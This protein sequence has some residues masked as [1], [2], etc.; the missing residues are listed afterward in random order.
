MAKRSMK[1]LLF[2]LLLLGN[3]TWM[4]AMSGTE[5]LTQPQV[6]V[7]VLYEFS[8]FERISPILN[9][10]KNATQ[11]AAQ[12]TLLLSVDQLLV[13]ISWP[14]ILRSGRVMTNFAC[15]V[16]FEYKERFSAP[17]IMDLMKKSD[18]KQGCSLFSKCAVLKSEM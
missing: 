10:P 2:L 9:D 4:V 15:F 7:S 3:L 6:K 14:R 13:A 11:Q 16:M 8:F 17:F 18:T 5:R 12:K 1:S